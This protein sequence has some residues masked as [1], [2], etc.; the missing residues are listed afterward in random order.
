MPSLDPIAV[1]QWVRGLRDAEGV[2]W[3]LEADRLR[4]LSVFES[5]QEYCSLQEQ[6]RRHERHSGEETWHKRA[7]SEYGRLLE[8][9][10]EA[11]RRAASR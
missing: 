7:A 2:A 4:G 1:R 9:F 8:A 6:A 3:R 5:V 10:R 11:A